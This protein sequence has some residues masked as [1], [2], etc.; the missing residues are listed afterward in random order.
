MSRIRSFIEKCVESCRNKTKEEKMV[1]KIKNIVDD[2]N[3]CMKNDKRNVPEEQD[4]VFQKMLDVM[5]NN[6]SNLKVYLQIKYMLNE[7]HEFI[8][9]IENDEKDIPEQEKIIGIGLLNKYINELNNIKNNESYS[10]IELIKI[11]DKLWK[12]FYQNLGKI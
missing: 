6:S 12:D 4:I 11:I 5:I 10:E 2:L 3:E 7:L 9:Y 8:K 1:L